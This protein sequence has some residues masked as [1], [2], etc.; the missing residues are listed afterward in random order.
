MTNE[1]IREAFERAG[2]PA[3]SFSAAAAPPREAP[4]RREPQPESLA[5]YRA[6]HP[7]VAGG[8]YAPPP[9][10]QAGYAPSPPPPYPPYMQMQPLQPSPA[11]AGFGYQALLWT[12]VVSA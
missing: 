6:P 7:R 10:P 8:P 1:E 9:P 12:S 11:P 5:P 4:V 2:L 3:P